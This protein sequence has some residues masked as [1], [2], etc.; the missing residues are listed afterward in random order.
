MKGVMPPGVQDLFSINLFTWRQLA[1][2]W[3]AL[4][5]PWMKQRAEKPGTKARDLSTFIS[6]LGSEL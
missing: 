1:S 6:K 5:M 2:P 4:L 3:Q